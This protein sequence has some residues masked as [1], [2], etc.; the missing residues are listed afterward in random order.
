MLGGHNTQE[1]RA[2][3]VTD[4]ALARDGIKIFD[5]ALIEQRPHA[6]DGDIVAAV[7]KKEWAVLRK[8]YRAGAEIELC[9]ADDDGE[10]I[11][12]AA[13]RIEILG[14]FRGLL[15]PIN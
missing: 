7:L 3:R 12:I 8:Y 11:R 9:S 2:F 14:V 13:D 15:R 5:I 1:I 6:R 10:I 4:D